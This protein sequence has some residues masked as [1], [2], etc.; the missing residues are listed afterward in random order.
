VKNNEDVIK[1]EYI[2]AVILQ[3]QSS[4]AGDYKTANKQ[5]KVLKK[6]FD[7]IQNG[8]LN[9]DI[10]IELLQHENDIVKSLAAANM[11][12]LNYEIKKAEQELE[13]IITKHNSDMIGFSAEM[14]LKVWRK[15]GFLKF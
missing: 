4:I 7:K 8:Y 12:A 15:Q 3:K 13:E 2:D 9:K 5:Y 6:I 11:L 10:L 1:K 14:C